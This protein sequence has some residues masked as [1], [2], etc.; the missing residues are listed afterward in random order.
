MFVGFKVA[1]GVTEA[2]LLFVAQCA[3]Q[4]TWC[5]VNACDECVPKLAVLIAI[6]ECLDNNGLATSKTPVEDNYDLSRL[7]AAVRMPRDSVWTMESQLPA[8]AASRGHSGTAAARSR[9]E[10][11]WDYDVKQ[12]SP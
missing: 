4:S 11:I 2:H 12:P 9:Y 3:L 6:V 7:N 1:R 8:Q 10:C 5:A